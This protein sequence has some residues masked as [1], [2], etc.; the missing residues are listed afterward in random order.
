MNINELVW[1]LVPHFLRLIIESFHERD[2][3]FLH[4]SLD[5]FICTVAPWIIDELIS[6][7]SAPI[8]IGRTED[9]IDEVVRH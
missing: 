3:F 4:S 2:G 1:F 7:S 9:L 6:R 5:L 8:G